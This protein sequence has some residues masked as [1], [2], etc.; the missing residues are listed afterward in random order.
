MYSREDREKAL[1]VAYKVRKEIIILRTFFATIREIDGYD[2][3]REQLEENRR[4][5]IFN[6]RK[7]TN[8]I[9]LRRNQGRLDQIEELF[10]FEGSLA[11]Q[12]SEVEKR[13][14]DLSKGMNKNAD[15]T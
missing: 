11:S 15:G 13:I 5:V 14:S 4:K 2:L 6:L 12:L 8:P 10:S 7:E 1:Q 9:F 3:L